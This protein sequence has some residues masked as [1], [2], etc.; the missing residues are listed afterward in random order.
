MVDLCELKKKCS[1]VNRTTLAGDSGQV[2]GLTKKPHVN[3]L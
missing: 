3:I 2:F 1:L